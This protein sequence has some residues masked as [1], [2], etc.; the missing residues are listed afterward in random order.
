MYQVK[1]AIQLIVSHRTVSYPL[2]FS[3][4]MQIVF[5]YRFFTDSFYYFSRKK[6]SIGCHLFPINRILFLFIQP[7]WQPRLLLYCYYCYCYCY[8]FCYNYRLRQPRRWSC[9]RLERC[10]WHR[11][12]W[13]WQ[14]SSLTWPG[15][16]RRSLSP[17]SRSWNDRRQYLHQRVTSY[18]R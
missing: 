11:R 17:L 5:Y 15:L 9:R 7:S 16:R 13:C 4:C 8:Y 18:A 6:C 3:G 1:L 14:S 12:P 2:C 10:R